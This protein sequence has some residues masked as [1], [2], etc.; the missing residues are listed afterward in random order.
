MQGLRIEVKDI[1]AEKKN[2]HQELVTLLMD[3]MKNLLD[4]Q[5]WLEKMYDAHS[6]R[7]EDIFSN[8]EERENVLN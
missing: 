2:T 8:H 1:V 4:T 3:I 5:K 7:L 6:R